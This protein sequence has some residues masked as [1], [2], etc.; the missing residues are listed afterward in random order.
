MK[1]VFQNV[2]MMKKS[3]KKLKVGIPFQN[4]HQYMVPAFKS[5]EGEKT[6]DV[7]TTCRIG[8]DFE[9]RKTYGQLYGF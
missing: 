3:S 5:E 2:Q 8:V 1:F 4:G 7:I 9:V 6:R